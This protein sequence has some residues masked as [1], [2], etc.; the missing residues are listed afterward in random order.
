ME[1]DL[2][3]GMVNIRN[4]HL[5]G[6]QTDLQAAGSMSVTGS[7]LN[8][9][10]NGNADLG[11][12]QNFDRDV[13]SSGKIVLATT[14]RGTA[15][16]P[17][18]N[19]QLSLEKASFSALGVPLGIS[20]ANGAVVFNGTTAQIRNLTAES[21]G[22][23]IA[24]TGFANY[25]DVLRF[26]VQTTA[27]NVRVRVQQGVTITAGANVRLAGTPDASNLTGTVTLDRVGYAPQSDFGSILTRS[28]PPVQSP[29]TP[30]LL[31]DNMKL[32]IRVRSAP[33]I[34]VQSALADNIQADADLRIRGSANQP[35]MLGRVTISEGKLNFFGA[36]YTVNTGSIGFFNP[37]RIEPILDVSLETQAQGVRVTLQVTGPVDNMKLSYTSD[38]PLQF[39]EIV[40]LL[41][42]G[43][44]PTSDPTILASQPQQPQRSFQQMGESAVLGQAV[45]NPVSSQLQRVFGVSSLKIDP[46]FTTGS[47]VPTAQ[48]AM[49]QRI[50]SNLTFTYVSSIDNANSTLIRMEWAFNPQW[51][52]VATRDQNG[53]VSLNFFYKRGFR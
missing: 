42:S 8:L 25:V 6:P 2:D 23:T 36:N 46:S 43:K 53:I 33:G 24:I 27:T 4:A 17:V 21:G 41:A 38:P 7:N 14:V 40:A 49:Q 9:N 20:N 44:A 51:S 13:Y 32:D 16:R 31:L 10:L 3:H 37:S 12:I 15:A 1:V 22:G 19:G 28:A 18:V 30:S 29:Q 11:V 52:A 47:N 26:G 34:V 35:G 45:A 50:T 39:Q 5:T 48:L